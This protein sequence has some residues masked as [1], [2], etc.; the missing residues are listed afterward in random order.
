[1]A[2][3]NSVATAGPG[4]GS[5]FLTARTAIAVSSGNASV[6]PSSGSLALPV[7]RGKIRVKIYNGGGTSPTLT[8]LQ[9]SITDGT[10]TVIVEDRNFGTA[11]VLSST[12]YYDGVFNF[13]VDYTTAGGGATGSLLGPA[14]SPAM[15]VNVTPTLGGT[16]PGATM[17]VEV[18]GEP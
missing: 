5:G 13:L 17:D 18:Y 6:V 14:N 11:V 12:N 3:V 9:I 16:S 4:Y 7:Y 15:V 2:I 1:M 8:K 10:N